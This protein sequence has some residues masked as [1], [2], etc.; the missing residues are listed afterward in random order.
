MTVSKRTRTNS[1]LTHEYVQR[2]GCLLKN[3]LERAR[4]QRFMLRH[5]HRSAFASQNQMRTGLTLN[6]EAQTLQCAGG[7]TAIY[8]ARQLHPNATTGSSTKCN[9]TRSG[10]AEGS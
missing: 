10:R 3:T 6:C 5:D 1:E 2:D 8:V 4:F 9:L 7:L